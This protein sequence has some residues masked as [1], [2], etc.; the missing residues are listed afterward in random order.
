MML[1]L[2]GPAL[3]MVE[4]VAEEMKCKPTSRVDCDSLSFAHDLG[5]G[6]EGHCSLSS[7]SLAP[8]SKDN[9]PFSCWNQA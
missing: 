7:S 2:S 8:E 5:L 1:N 4:P 9:I 6:H 3:S